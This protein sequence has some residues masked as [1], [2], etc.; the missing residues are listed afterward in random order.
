MSPHAKADLGCGL[1]VVLL[2]LAGFYSAYV[3]PRSPVYAQVGPTLIP[4]VASAALTLLGAALVASA[5]RGGWS[6][7]VEELRE[8]DPINWR[9][10]GLL[11]AGL[12]ANVALIDALGFVF[13]ATAM[14]V[15]VA[16]AF[17]SRKLIRDLL[18][19]ATITL[20]AFL[21][22]DKALGV[23]IGAGILEGVL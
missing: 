7:A 18:I 20:S 16:A 21:F 3:I 5:M 14:F 19:G 6:H 2:G 9:A 23:N 22:F 11:W 1:F 4:Y 15:L 13:S 12:I 17:G 8:L 10:F